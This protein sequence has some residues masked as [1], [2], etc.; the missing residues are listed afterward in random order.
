MKKSNIIKRIRDFVF[1][2]T[3][4]YAFYKNGTMNVIWSNGKIENFHGDCTVWYRE[5][6]MERCSTSMECLLLELW[7]YNKRWNGAY[8]YAH[9]DI[10]NEKSRDN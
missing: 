3:V 1:G 7:Q 6:L 4:D 10:Q 5:P 9:K 2:P 8:P